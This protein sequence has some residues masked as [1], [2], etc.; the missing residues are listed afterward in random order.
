[1]TAVFFAVCDK[2]YCHLERCLQWL[3]D[4][5]GRTIGYIQGN[6]AMLNWRVP[7]EI[8]EE[9]FREAKPG[10]IGDYKQAVQQIFISKKAIEG[11]PDPIWVS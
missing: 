7:R 1:M 5:K 2:S 9:E 3:I 11:F 4:N 8:T 10:T 6:V